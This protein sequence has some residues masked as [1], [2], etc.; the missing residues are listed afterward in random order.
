MIDMYENQLEEKEEAP[1][2]AEIEEDVSHMRP[3]QLMEVK[4]NRKQIPAVYHWLSNRDYD[5]L[6]G[7]VLYGEGLHW[8]R[9]FLYIKPRCLLIID[10]VEGE[11]DRK[12]KQLFHGPPS[13]SI[14]RAGGRYIMTNSDSLHCIVETLFNGPIEDYRIIKGKN[15]MPFQGWYSDRFFSIEKAP[16]IENFVDL[17]RDM[18]YLATIIVPLGK[19]DPG[20]CEIRLHDSMD[21]NES[22]PA[23]LHIEI[24]EPW[25]RTT[26]T[27]MPSSKLC[28]DVDGP[29]RIPEISV[30]RKKR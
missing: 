17:Q 1:E 26:V 28:G 6:E 14:T 25:R 23:P 20:R 24:L 21:W 22:G 10:V 15:N 7:G 18:T 8:S 29:E 13:V 16:V 9:A 30:E 2:Q 12:A 19:H 4:P 3:F 27:I 11:K 5:Y